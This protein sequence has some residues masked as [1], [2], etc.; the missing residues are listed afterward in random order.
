MAV[1]TQ[2]ERL[3]RQN[4]FASASVGDPWDRQYPHVPAINDHAFQGVCRLIRQK[5]QDPNLNCAGLILGEVGSGKTHLLGRILTYARQSQPPLAFAYIQPLEAPEQTYRYLLR[6][7]TVN[8]CRPTPEAP[9]GTQLE[10]VLAAVCAEVIG[11]HCRPQGHQ[12]LQTILR[13]RL[14][15]LHYL[16]P[17]VLAYAQSWAVDLLCTLYPAMST[18]F[19]DVLFQ[20][21][22][23]AQRAAAVSWLRG[24]GFGPSDAE[25]IE[26]AP[27]RLE[28]EARDILVSLGFLMARYGQP[29][30][31]CFDRLENLESAAQLQAF[32]KMLEFLVDT[33][34]GMLPLACVR[35]QQWE[36]TFR[37]ALNQHVTSRLETNRFTLQGCTAEQALELVRQRLA[38]VVSADPG[39]TLFPFHDAELRQMFQTGFHS[40]RVVVSRANERLQQVLETGVAAPVAPQHVLQDAFDHQVQNVFQAFDRYPPDRDRLR[41]ALN[42]YLSHRPSWR[43]GHL[44]AVQRAE[45]EP[46]YIDL[47]GRF[48]VAG[49]P[50]RPV[51]ML[52]DVEP[53]P[54]A[55]SASLARGVDFLR[56]QATG[57]AVYIRETRCPFPLP[58]SWKTT[59][60]K[61]EQFQALGG[62]VVAL[63]QDRAARWYALTLL[64]YAVR[65]GDI[66]LV[67]VQHRIRPVTA[68][69]FA[70]FIQHA[71]YADTDAAFRDVEAVFAGPDGSALS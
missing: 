43:Y 30:V 13:D 70:D 61:L 46:R 11:R 7:V 42:L 15:L 45:V 50:S 52:I 1:E 31:L 6:E 63:D 2:L 62:H 54:A 55:V 36:E 68:D 57:I 65:E 18:R 67:D 58:K 38:S 26:V 22:V 53:H 59:S 33:T 64:S 40:P 66:A 56:A 3:R 10:A 20:Y 27:A 47:T 9:Y 51:I 16:R 12:K 25:R 29:L 34:Q 69:Q 21:G 49:A 28:Q 48:E 5:V 23:P 41:R 32:G 4:P 37:G 8:L 39:N 24:G 35:G 14:N 17:S 60:E 71:F 44:E 19:L